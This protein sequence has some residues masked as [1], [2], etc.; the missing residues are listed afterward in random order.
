MIHHPARY[1][2]K[3]YLSRRNHT[4]KRISELLSLIDLGGLSADQVKLIDDDM[5]FPR[6][7][8]PRDLGHRASQLFL[9]KEGIY[10]A[11]RG[12]KDMQKAEEILGTKT[13][14][15]L[16]ETFILSPL[17]SNQAVKK[18]N[19]KIPDAEITVRSY[20][21]FEHYF[22]NRDEM[23]GDKWGS[24]ITTRENANQEWLQ[25]AMDSRG[26]S[27][28][29]MLLWKTG[30]GALK[31]IEANKMF[32]DLRD[33]AYMAAMQIA[34]YPPGR[35]HSEMLLNYTRAAKIGQEGID[36]TENAVKD[37]VK[38]FNAFRMRH[39]ENQTPSIK[40]LTGGRY[41]DAESGDSGD[42]KLGYDR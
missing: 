3:F 39:V 15:D 9:R 20:E 11:W 40:E 7:Y 27:G 25:L 28:V 1:W 5:D 12:K 14:R 26:A 34:M 36:S 38:A 10:D 23:S 19:Q 18:I 32:T 21:L 31:Q 33:I 42:D 22:W 13:L 29:R 8:K 4:H 6:P 30:T 37:V 35:N 2:V 16:V 17:K 41:S 24:F